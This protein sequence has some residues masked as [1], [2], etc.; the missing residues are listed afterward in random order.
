[1]TGFDAWVVR[2]LLSGLSLNGELD[3][4]SGIAKRMANHLAAVS[5]EERQLVWNAMLAVT[6]EQDDIITAVAAADPEGPAPEVQATPFATMGDIRK[7]MAN[8]RWLWDG[9][10]P[11][12]RVVGL[13]SLEGIGKTR[14][15]MDLC[16]RVW[17]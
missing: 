8:V 4:L 5:L 14:T 3:R 13:A 1:M 16:R 12:S 2:R 10:I 11:A 15:A 9:W 17:L 7:I 6:G